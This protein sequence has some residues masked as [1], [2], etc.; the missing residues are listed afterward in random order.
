MHKTHENIYQHFF[1]LTA[2][3]A[4][5]NVKAKCKFYLKFF[6]HILL[7]STNIYIKP[8]TTFRGR[9]GTLCVVGNTLQIKMMH[10]DQTYPIVGVGVMMTL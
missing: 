2:Q 4:M 10:L 1:H 6:P 3:E 8:I 7:Y 9:W 5:A